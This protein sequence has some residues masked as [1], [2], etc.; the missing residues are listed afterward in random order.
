M[1]APISQNGTIENSNGIQPG[2]LQVP[3]FSAPDPGVAVSSP[4]GGAPV[5]Y[6]VDS[7][8]L[9]GAGVVTSGV[10]GFARLVINPI[11]GTSITGLT[12][13][14]DPTTA[15]QV[16]AAINTAIA[17]YQN[18]FVTNV[19]IATASSVVVNINFDYGF[20]NGTILASTDGSARSQSNGFLLDY[21]QV[22]PSV[23]GL[24]GTNPTGAG[25]LDVTDAQLKEFG[26]S[27]GTGISATS[28]EVDGYVGINT[29]ANGVT[30]AYGANQ[31]VPGRVGAVGAIEHE[32]SEVLGRQAVLGV[33]SNGHSLYS[34]LDL[35][36]YSAPGVL[37]LTAGAADYFSLNNGTT[38]LSGNSFNNAGTGGDAGDWASATVPA[39]AF[40]AFLATGTGGTI[41]A[42]DTTVLTTIGLQLACF[43][44][45]TRVLTARGDR[46][47]ETLTEGDELRTLLGGS[48]RIIWLGRREIDLTRRPDPSSAWPVRV[49][50]GA[51]APGLP[52]RD[53]YLSPDHAV[54]VDGVL[55]PV[56]LLIN[57]TSVRQTPMDH[58]VYYHVELEQHDV[59]LA[60]GLPSETY[61]DA[62]DRDTFSGGRVTALHP[63]FA[64]R[65][66]ETAGC[67]PMVM[68]GP[69]LDAVRRRL[70]ARTGPALAI[71]S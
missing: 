43:A 11:F 12:G 39:D 64:A 42:L 60:E 65:R 16:E 59:I 34:L 37:D 20:V 17:F 31:S 26:I 57:G 46:P 55:I 40:D 62:G 13:G 66:W 33:V 25:T 49:R 69:V 71:A 23:A 7:S 38:A 54:Y 44:A 15:A 35:F 27:A 67:A 68:T 22:Q 6:S 48:G 3:D 9:L 58:V 19:P 52:A 70:A 53:L 61:L 29:I 30:M 56:K 36:R 8:A 24:P 4:A 10:S 18:T 45:G 32:I 14:T 1:A 50:A 21:S 63:G 2:D 51:F 41:S 5:S 28:A 47:I